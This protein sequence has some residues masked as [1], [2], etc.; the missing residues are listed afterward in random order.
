M[1][2][3]NVQSKKHIKFN[4]E[5]SVILIPTKDEYEQCNVNKTL[6]WTREELD[7]FKQSCNEEILNLIKRHK[8]MTIHQAAKL[9]YQPGNMN[10]VYDKTNFD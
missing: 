3:L 7:S 10:I 2:S 4:F 9:L 8:Y 5:V 1:Y 6:W